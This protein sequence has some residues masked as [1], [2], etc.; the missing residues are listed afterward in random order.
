MESNYRPGD[1][2]TGFRFYQ[3]YRNQGSFLSSTSRL[4][5]VGFSS[6]APVREGLGPEADIGIQK[7]GDVSH[8][9]I[10]ILTALSAVPRVVSHRRLSRISIVRTPHAAHARNK[11][12]HA[13]S[14]L[15]SLGHRDY[16][17][18]LVI[19][20]QLRVGEYLLSVNYLIY[21]RFLSSESLG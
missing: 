5:Q 16:V 20:Q 14:A 3:R 15:V 2:Y 19:L 17:P 18:D 21:L 4:F 12:R 10:Q 13:L 6:S 11:R 8:T 7:Y 9:K 1:G